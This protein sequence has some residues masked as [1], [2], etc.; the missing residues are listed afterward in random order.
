MG[1]CLHSNAMNLVPVKIIIKSEGGLF[2]SSES[3]GS[4]TNLKGEMLGSG[5]PVIALH[6]LHLFFFFALPF[7]SF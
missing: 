5:R 3:M 1:G 2:I 6:F 4:N 7:S